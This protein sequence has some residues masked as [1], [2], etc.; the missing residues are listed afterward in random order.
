VATELPPAVAKFQADVTQ[1]TEPLQR[2][3]EATKQFGDRT[4]AAALK[5]REMGLKTM[6]AADRAAAAMKIAQDAAEKYE[7][8]EID[9]AAAQRAAADAAKSQARADLEL[10]ALQ[11]SVAK[12]TNNNANAQ[13]NLKKKTEDATQGG[14]G[15]MGMLKKI[16]IIAG[17]ATSSLEPLAAGLIAV[18]GG[19]ASG[20]TSAALGLG[21]FGLVAKSAFTDVTNA[22][23]AGKNLTGGLGELQRSLKSATKEWDGF[24]AHNASG[25]AKIM[26]QG[27][28]LLPALLK[29]LQEFLTPAESGVGRLVTLLSKDIKSTGFAQVM[30]TLAK[31]SGSSI[32]K[33][34]KA[35][36]DIVGAFGHLMATFAPFAQVVLSGLDKMTGGFE[37]WAAGLSKTKGFA[38]FMKMV[39]TEGPQAAGVLKNL[40]VIA[41]LFI[42]DMAGSDSN[43]TWVKYLPALTQFAAGF[44]K[45]H[46][47]LVENIMNLM[48]YKS[49][50]GQAFGAMSKGFG[51]LKG[52]YTT[53]ST[54]TKALKNLHAGFTDAAK[55][56]DEATGKWGTAGGQLKNFAKGFKNVD[57]AAKESTGKMG[58]FGGAVKKALTFPS[59]S[60][61]N[62]K[63]GMNDADYAA[64]DASGMMGTLGGNI[65]KAVTAVKGW[66][67][68]SK[69]SAAATKVWSGIQVVFNA[70][71][72]ANPIILVVAAVAILVAGIIFAYIHFKVF[73][74]AVNDVGR[75]LR[76]GFL[77]ALHAVEKAVDAVIKFVKE[78]WPLIVGIIIGPI[79]IV[80]ALVLTHWNTVKHTVMTA[81]DAIIGFVK[82]HWK[83]IVSIIG[84]PLAA[85]IIFVTSHWNTIK[86]LFSEGVTDVINFL[87]R[88]PSEI[89]RLFA[90]ANTWLFDAG[91][92]IIMGLVHGIEDLAMAPVHA[93]EDIGHDITGAAKR[94][95][96][97][98]SPSTVFRNLGAQITTGMALGIAETSQQVVTKAH[99]LA[100][101]VAKA[102]T[103]GELTNAQVTALGN[104]IAD[105]LHAAL[106]TAMSR[107]I[108]GTLEKELTETG[109]NTKASLAALQQI[110][111][112]NQGG[113]ISVSEASGLAK[114]VKADNA[115][116]TTLA[117]ERSK[118]ANQI[119]AAKAY[120][121]STAQSAE[122]T[123]SLAAAAGTGTTPASVT[124]II[125]TL[126]ADVG[127]IRKFATDIKKLAKEGLS[128][129]YLS[130][131]IA[132]GPDQGA[133]LAAELVSAGISQIHQINQAESQI[134]SA[135]NGL[136]YAAANAMYDSGKQAGKGFLS[137]LKAQE[138]SINGIMQK[139]AKNMVTTL[140]KELGISSPSRVMMQHGMMVAEGLAQGMESGT[141]RVAQ[142]ASRLS[143]AAVTGTASLS[144]RAGVS[145]SAVQPIVI[146]LR[147]EVTGKM[148]D[149]EVWSALQQQTFRYNIRNT[150]VVT[151][152]VK[153]GFA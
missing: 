144:H 76:T 91:K 24:V 141:A 40:L 36:F 133:P 73:R 50:A 11:D 138:A 142:A 20:L 37:K 98:L 17:F 52:G 122:S 114:W 29:T 101:A 59:T 12:A 87:K 146:N 2:A 139:I 31:N 140:R 69:I 92:N 109:K 27:I 33:L 151:G 104:R 83:L 95:L 74:D 72:D 53:I 130:Q 39:K 135:S 64:S 18:T 129:S 49:I 28:G 121:T 61:S 1:Y 10:A 22:N 143:S 136:G 110:W 26:S 153:P 25:V 4:D 84:G 30:S 145:G 60:L 67:I 97:I 116:L 51:V 96:G 118:I 14:F 124:S 152:G 70:I 71:M 100:N 131:L 117:N 55:A 54:T 3:I 13:G 35:I 102:A 41:G 86:H 62:L 78:H 43:M 126:H 38:E 111:S 134:T 147:S 108:N 32:Y 6:E 15:E 42:K 137:G 103:E 48:M 89:A 105:Q 80:A 81:V 58:T 79:G 66:A 65:T 123:Y 9:L 47:A 149:K 94:V 127:K 68:W 44:M 63:K 34:G 107:V 57:D 106:K 113:L 45:T 46:S 150:G 19:L 77:T 85:V 128:K 93:V 90:S 120:A 8:G 88:L 56:A 99:N 5:A 125:S 16:W 7:R 148:N 21:A 112:A 82:D 75:A 132:M 115:R 119:A 23:T